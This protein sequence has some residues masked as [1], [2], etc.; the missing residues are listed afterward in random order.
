MRPGGAIW[1]FGGGK[2]AAV[3]SDAGLVDDYYIAVQPVLLG[4]GIPLW[5]TPHGRTELE[6]TSA[7][8]W[9]GG[10]AALRYSRSDRTP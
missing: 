3:M 2:L 4:D 7:C 8:A 9:P 5:T 6:L 10:I 1:L